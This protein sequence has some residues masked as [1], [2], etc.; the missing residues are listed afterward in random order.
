MANQ[1]QYLFSKKLYKSDTDKLCR[2]IIG[3]RNVQAFILPLYT[4]EE[5]EDIHEGTEHELR[6]LDIHS[7]TEESFK[8]KFFT[9]SKCYELKS[10]WSNFVKRRQLKVGDVIHFYS[11]IDTNEL[12]IRVEQDI[13]LELRLGSSNAVC[14]KEIKKPEKKLYGEGSQKS[15]KLKLEPR[16]LS[17]EMLYGEDSKKGKEIDLELRISSSEASCS[18]EFKT[19]ED[20]ESPP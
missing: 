15:K 18:K 11:R 4:R 8:F 3:R 12:C 1:I 5:R 17:S 9:S 10:G 7:N 2:I 16:P 14:G 20:I 13:D 19:D 6:C